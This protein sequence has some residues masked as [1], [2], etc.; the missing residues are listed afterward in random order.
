VEPCIA[1]L[2]YSTK[3]SAKESDRQG[4]R[5]SG[6]VKE[7]DPDLNVDGELQLDAS[8]CRRSQPEGSGQ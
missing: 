2:S 8:S 3:G 5:R 1:L 4:H 6:H 7:K